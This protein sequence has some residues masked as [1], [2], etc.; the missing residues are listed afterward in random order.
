MGTAGLS[1]DT[2]SPDAARPA[3]LGFDPDGATVPP[4][5]GAAP[6]TVDMADLLVRI[7][8]RMWPELRRSMRAHSLFIA[9]V[10]VHLGA[11]LVIPPLFGVAIPYSPTTYVTTMLALIVVALV[12]FLLFYAAAL[13]IA[14]RPKNFWSYMWGELAQKVFTIERICLA[15][16]TVLFFP[17]MAAT[18]SY[19]K[20]AIPAFQ[21]FTWDARFAAWDRFL[22]GGYDPWR[23]LQPIVGHPFVTALLSDGYRVWFGVTYCLLLWI[24]ID[25]RRPRLRM[26]Y[27]L[28]FALSWILLGN[29]AATLLSSAGPAFFGRV[30]GLADPFVPLIDYLRE[31]NKVAIV[32]AVEIQEMLWTWYKNGDTIV[33]AGISA[34]P[35]LH[36]GIAFS[37]FLLGQAISRPLGLLGP[38]YAA[39]IL[40]SSVHLG[41]HYAVDGYAAIVGTWIIWF[42]T[43]W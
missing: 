27:L 43:G 11:A 12:V 1:I 29:M 25:T 33:G 4:G 18:F 5:A 31:A 41:W 10:L 40:I 24:M 6:G 36:V 26:R 3:S 17:I 22:H 2:M 20:T 34:M 32:P 37:F 13:A 30:T 38:P 15:L 23:L 28:T 21:P 16:P 9:I 7:G 42:C 35:S 39:I 19:F 8:H 14:V